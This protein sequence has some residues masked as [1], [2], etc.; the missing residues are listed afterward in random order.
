MSRT[1]VWRLV[2]A[3]ALVAL[4]STAALPARAQTSVEVRSR[5]LFDQAR[6]LVEAGKYTEACPLFQASHDL[7]A[8]GGTALQAGNCY[9][10]IGKLDRALAMYQLVLEDPKT[11]Q[12]PERMQIA[13]E[14]VSALKKQ[15][16]PEAAPSPPPAAPS[17]PPPVPVP[18]PPVAPDA[19]DEGGPKRLAGYT[20]LGVGGAGLLVGAVTG[21]LALAQAKQ[22]TKDCRGS[23]CPAAD[24]PA[25]NAAM[26]KGWVSNVSLGVG[27]AAV[28][29]GAVLLILNRAPSKN[30]MATANGLMLRF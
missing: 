2:G 7:H 15:L 10:K 5:A 22:V 6:A 28:A 1:R 16:Q 21:G 3:A 20:L 26:T 23:V 11:A 27:V 17:P 9:E 8:T 24:K 12:N 13:T 14:R 30:V 18:P 25:A 19:A 29:A 4:G